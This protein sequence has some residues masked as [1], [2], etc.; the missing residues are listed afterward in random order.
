MN[1]QCNELDVSIHFL[2]AKDSYT[3]DLT[4]K[5]YMEAIPYIP[6]VPD[7][8]ATTKNRQDIKWFLGKCTTRDLMDV[9]SHPT[10]EQLAMKLLKIQA[11]VKRTR[12]LWRISPVLGPTVF[13]Y[14]VEPDGFMNGAFFEV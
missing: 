12:K 3:K 1:K 8:N 6:L 7:D 4:T 5:P 14:M 9:R 10:L 2:D 11:R 13:S